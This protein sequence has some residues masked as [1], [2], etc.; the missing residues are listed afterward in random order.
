MQ[1]NEFD[2]V[3][4]TR[5]IISDLTPE[6]N[7][8]A[9]YSYGYVMTVSSR[10]CLGVPMHFIGTMVGEE[11]YDI[12]S[13][14]FLLN[15]MTDI[16]SS[17]KNELGMNLLLCAQ[18]G[19]VKVDADLVH[20][21]PEFVESSFIAAKDGIV[22][23]TARQIKLADEFL[24]LY[25]ESD[26][27]MIDDEIISG[28]GDLKRNKLKDGQEYNNHAIIIETEI[29]ENE[30]I[31]VQIHQGALYGKLGKETKLELSPCGTTWKVDRVEFKFLT[32]QPVVTEL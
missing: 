29:D 26:M 2:T 25:D 10:N 31:Y 9:N 16:L 30:N 21:T 17:S 11:I 12:D 24:R 32:S 14:K 6:R 27:Y 3:K 22:E 4:L 20:F 28:V 18:V 8:E 1:S 19:G 13:E 23:V 5:H 15:V 7:D